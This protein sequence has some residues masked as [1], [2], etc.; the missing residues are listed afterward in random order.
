MLGHINDID[1]R[2]YMVLPTF[3][4]DHHLLLVRNDE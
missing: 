4:D 1:D 3:F 2:P